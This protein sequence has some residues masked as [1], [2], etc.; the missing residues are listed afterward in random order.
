ML[1]PRP[2]ASVETEERNEAMNIIM[3]TGVATMLVSLAACGN[4]ETDKGGP[5]PAATSKS[6]ANIHTATGTVDSI[7]GTDA[8]ISHDPI[9]SLDWP[10]MK[11]TFTATDAALLE[12]VKAGDR[13]SFAFSKSG[14]ASTLTSISKQ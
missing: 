6:E 8:T 13:V 3:K 7:S 9:K 14:S 2:P 10:A 11:M 4:V 5:A 12:G 1:A